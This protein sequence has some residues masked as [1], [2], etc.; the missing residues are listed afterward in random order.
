VTCPACHGSLEVRAEGSGHLHFTCRI[1]HAFSMREMVEAYE[2]FFEDTLWTAIRAA[3][4]LQQLLRDVADDRPH[5]PEDIPE[6]N[7]ESRRNRAARQA[8]TLRRLLEEYEPIRFSETYD[9]GER[10]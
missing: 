5:A 8:A 9:E 7:Y 1:G 10:E 3:E 2:R 6:A 4:E